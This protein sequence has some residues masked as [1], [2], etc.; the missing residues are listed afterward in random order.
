[1]GV[2]AGTCWFTSSALCMHS[3][4]LLKLQ[5]AD[6]H[7]GSGVSCAIL[8]I[9]KCAN[10]ECA[11]KVTT[12]SSGVSAWCAVNQADYVLTSANLTRSAHSGSLPWAAPDLQPPLATIGIDVVEFGH[13][14]AL[15]WAP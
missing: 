2:L 4:T 8:H 1:M 6:P 3:G 13:W 10:T 11:F 5:C 15:V 12:D 9:S 7:H 14:A